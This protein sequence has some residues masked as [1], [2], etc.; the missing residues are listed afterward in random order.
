MIVNFSFSTIF[1]FSTDKQ[2]Q[3]NCISTEKDQFW[4]QNGTFSNAKSVLFKVKM[5]IRP[6]LVEMRSKLDILIAHLTS[7]RSW[8]ASL[9][10]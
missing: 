9:S 7:A 8:D 3:E 2:Q 6:I 10:I 1:K 5:I 4:I